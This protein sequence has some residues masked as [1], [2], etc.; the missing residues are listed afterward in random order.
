M[1][2]TTLDQLLEPILMS[3]DS[4]DLIFLRDRLIW[5]KSELFDEY[6]PNLYQSF[7]DCLA[8]WLSNV[9]DD[10]SR[11]FM[12]RLLEHFFFVGKQQF[13]SLS[14][15][16][17]SDQ[18]IR[19]IVDILNLDICDTNLNTHIEEAINHTWFCPITDSMRINSFLKVNRIRGHDHRPD[20]RSL[21]EFA[22]SEKLRSYV[23]KEKINQ[24]VLLEDF[25]G[26]GAQM[27]KTVIWASETLP[28]TPILV[29]P[30]ICCP[31][32]LETGNDIADNHDNISFSPC[33]SLRRE[34]FVE[35]VAQSGEPKV[36]SEIREIINSMKHRLGDWKHHPFGYR[37][38]GALVALFSN[39]PDN[40]LPMIHDHSD[41]WSPLFSR[42]RRN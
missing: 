13:D 5:L 28:K 26:T 23:S 33:L 10:N 25:V 35:E 17:F 29:I 14:R 7:D 2:V 40:T 12:F 34:F 9:T 1:K 20:W 11:K 38:T 32:G 4:D 42:I 27:R 19:W 39:C 3:D 15:S 8:N 31:S 6:E 36:F 21:R 22:D 30:L 24:I 41:Q 16:A 37:G 18:T